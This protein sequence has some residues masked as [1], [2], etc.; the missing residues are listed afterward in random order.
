MRSQRTVLTIIIFILIG[1]LSNMSG[2]YIIPY[3]IILAP[4]YSPI[5][6]SLLI[7]IIKYIIL[8]DQNFKVNLMSQETFFIGDEEYMLEPNVDE[9]LEYHF[10]KDD[11]K[12]KKV[13]PFLI[14]LRPEDGV[15]VPKLYIKL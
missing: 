3:W 10:I 6:I 1:V 15:Y 12:M 5:I 13:P 14:G 4:I 11:E 7:F 9:V 8:R 2:N